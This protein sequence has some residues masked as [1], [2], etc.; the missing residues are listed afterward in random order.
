VNQ[1]EMTIRAQAERRFR[2]TS[3]AAGWRAEDFR[4]YNGWALER[5]V[6]AIAAGGEEAAM[7]LIISERGGFDGMARLDAEGR[8]TF[9]LLERCLAVIAEARAAG[10]RDEADPLAAAL[11]AY[12]ALTYAEERHRELKREVAQRF[13]AL[14]EARQ[15]AY[16]EAVAGQETPQAPKVLD[17]REAQ[18]ARWI[19]G[20]K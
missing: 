16:I 2:E 10:A 20:E 12:Q 14:D 11:D 19:R 17:E 8:E 5:A 9:P 7:R 6:I 18:V 13:S 15:Q 4:S 1:Q 3:E